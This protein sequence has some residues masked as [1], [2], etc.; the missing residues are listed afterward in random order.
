MSPADL[1]KL[2]S[3]GLITAFTFGRASKRDQGH[4]P[5]G[6]QFMGK[7]TLKI[8]LSTDYGENMS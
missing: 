2:A 3:G 8:T 5:R 6:V 1:S 7:L 4:G